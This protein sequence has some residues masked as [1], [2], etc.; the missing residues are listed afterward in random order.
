YWEFRNRV[1]LIRAV[2]HPSL[3]A[4]EGLRLKASSSALLCAPLPA[5]EGLRLKA[6]SSALLCTPLPAG[7]G[8]G[9]EGPGHP[10]CNRCQAVR[11][12]SI[13][14]T[15]ELSVPERGSTGSPRCP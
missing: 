11:K 3:P 8:W 1:T 12:R 13:A 6:S 15:L 7:E 5:G 10:H 9:G 4:G 14:A 2:A